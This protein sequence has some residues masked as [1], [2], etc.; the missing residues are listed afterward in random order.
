LATQHFRAYRVSEDAHGEF[1]GRVTQRRLDEL[2]AGDIL[3]RVRYSSLNYKDALSASGNRG[4]TRDYPHTPGI[5]AA[6][7]VV[8]SEHADWRAGDEVIVTGYGLGMDTAGGLAEY[9]RV[10]ADWV[11]PRPEGLSAWQAMALGTA[12]FTAALCVQALI[13]REVMPETGEILVT[14]ASGGVGSLAVALLAQLGYPVVAASGKP[15][16]ADWLRALG[17]GEVVGRDAL[18][19]DS[20]RALLAERWAGSVD[21]VG[22]PALATTLKQVR[23]H[24]AVACCGL[25]A[26]PELV[27]TMMPFILRGVGLLGVSSQNTPMQRRTGIWRAFAGAWQLQALASIARTISLDDVDAGVAQLLAGEARGRLVV[28]IGGDWEGE[29]A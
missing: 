15:D 29:T 6:G 19:D 10:P 1:L 16:A 14:G 2:P 12:G 28:A 13:E 8:A 9:I 5:D 7:V 24:G 3:V 25:V 22:G 27:T 21:T 4:V 26:S 18:V 17:A 20:P 23:Q 11:V